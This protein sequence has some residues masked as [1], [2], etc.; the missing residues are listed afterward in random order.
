MVTARAAEVNTKAAEMARTAT[1][2]RRLDMAS[3]SSSRV[4]GCRSVLDEISQNLRGRSSLTR[5]S[6][7]G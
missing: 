5:F 4:E 1:T 3:S 2:T 7:Y 6:S